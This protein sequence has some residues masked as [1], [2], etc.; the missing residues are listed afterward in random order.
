M[1]A[2]A[3][4]SCVVAAS[5][6]NAVRPR[7]VVVQLCDGSWRQ[8]ALSLNSEAPLLRRVSLCTAP[9]LQVQYLSF[10]SR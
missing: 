4:W 9:H 7:G 10:Q 2:C 6:S 1:L 5:S 3:D 8:L